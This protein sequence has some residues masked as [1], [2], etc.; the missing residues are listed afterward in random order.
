MEFLRVK[1][2]WVPFQRS[3]RP[4]PGARP[5][6]EGSGKGAGSGK[7]LGA[8]QGEPTQLSMGKTPTHRGAALLWTLRESPTLG[9]QTFLCCA[10]KASAEAPGPQGEGAGWQAGAPPLPL[11]S[12]LSLVYTFKFQIR[13]FLEKESGASGRGDP[14]VPAFPEPCPGALDTALRAGQWAALGQGPAVTM[15]HLG[16]PQARD[17]PSLRTQSILPGPRPLF[18]TPSDQKLPVLPLAPRS[19]HLHLPPRTWSPAHGVPSSDHM[20]AM[21]GKLGPL[22]SGTSTPTPSPSPGS[23]GGLLRCEAAAG[24]LNWEGG[25]DQRRVPTGAPWAA[26]RVR[27][28]GGW[29]GVAAGPGAHLWDTAPFSVMASHHMVKPTL[30]MVLAMKTRKTTKA[31]TS[32]LRK[33]WRKELQREREAVTEPAW[34]PSTPAAPG[35]GR[36]QPRPSGSQRGPGPQGT[37]WGQAGSLPFP[38]RPSSHS[39]AAQPVLPK[40]RSGAHLMAETGPLFKGRSTRFQSLE[41]SSHAGRPDRL[42]WRLTLTGTH[43]GRL[44]AR[45]SAQLS[46]TRTGGRMTLL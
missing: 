38:E 37:G 13:L 43:Q 9:A 28:G 18:P 10:P 36:G 46:G 2:H 32:R 5:R 6:S 26:G 24:S 31:L 11:T 21:M 23:L 1:K 7:W 34:A 17:S 45:P 22:T 39:P 30:T 16:L 20:L 25:A 35:G 15:L 44:P 14:R 33:A 42:S 27:A 19:P 8:Q 29:W 12:A 41:A 4:Y 40:P 3:P